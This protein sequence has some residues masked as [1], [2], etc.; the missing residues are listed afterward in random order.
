[1]TPAE[2]RKHFAR[3]V[4]TLS[5]EL[6]DLPSKV[7]QNGVI[8]GIFILI[9]IVLVWN[10]FL[11]MQLAPFVAKHAKTAA[12]FVNALI[13]VIWLMFEAIKLVVGTIINIV[14]TLSGKSTH[15]PSLKAKPDHYPISAEEIR[16]K[17]PS[18]QCV[19]RQRKSRRKNN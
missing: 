16:R 4:A 11:F 19:S 18:S 15:G 9:G 1:M 12:V 2:L 10:R 3:L 5:R 14:R 8:I 6:L 17:Y 7:I 13:E